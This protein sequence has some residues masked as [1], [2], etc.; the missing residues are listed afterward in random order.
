MTVS[1]CLQW[2]CTKYNE[3]AEKPFEV[4]LVSAIVCKE[5]LKLSFKFCREFKFY[6]IE[7]EYA[8]GIF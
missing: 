2:N 3:Y 5:Q 7:L 4:L 1:L 8:M 6:C